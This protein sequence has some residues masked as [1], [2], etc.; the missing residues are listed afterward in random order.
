VL[1]QRAGSSPPPIL[2]GCEGGIVFFPKICGKSQKL[3]GMTFSE[4][5]ILSRNALLSADFGGCESIGSKIFTWN[6]S[7]I[8][9]NICL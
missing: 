4:F 5:S 8:F 1:Q 3:G 6:F 2:A 7:C 9:H